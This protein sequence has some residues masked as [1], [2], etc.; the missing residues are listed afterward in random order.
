[1]ATTTT[2]FKTLA[3]IVISKDPALIVRPTLMVGL[4]LRLFI[5]K[6]QSHVF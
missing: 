2:E 1:M 5:L 4:L 3:Q 6:M